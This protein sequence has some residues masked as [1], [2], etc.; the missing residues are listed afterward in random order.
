MNV[1][2]FVN[3][4]KYVIRG[5][6]QENAFIKEKSKQSSNKNIFAYETLKF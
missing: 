6:F 4:L 5:Y 1:L 3:R 2:H